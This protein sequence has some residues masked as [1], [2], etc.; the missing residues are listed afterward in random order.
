MYRYILD[1]SFSGVEIGK[2]YIHQLTAGGFHCESVSFGSSFSSGTPV[3]V[4]ATVNH[5]DDS[6]AVHDSSFVWVEEV[7]TSGFKACLVQGGQ[8]NGGDTT[9]D[10]FAFK[11]SQSGVHDGEASFSLFTTGTKCNEVTF[12]QVGKNLST[13]PNGFLDNEREGKKC[14]T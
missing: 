1:I 10:W 9:I 6:S 4:F 3:R 7:T 8:G 11:G 2:I 12:P 14:L 5:G 13:Y